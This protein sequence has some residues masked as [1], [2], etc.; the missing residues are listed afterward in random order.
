MEAVDFSK[1][2]AEAEAVTNSP[3]PDTLGAAAQNKNGV[4]VC[5]RGE[6]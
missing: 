1:L 4:L 5:L 6:G 2:E 3:L